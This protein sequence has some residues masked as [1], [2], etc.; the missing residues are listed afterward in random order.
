MKIAIVGY[1]IVGQATHCGLLNLVPVTIHDIG[2]EEFDSTVIENHDLIFMCLPTD[3]QEHIQ[4]LLDE[5]KKLSLKNPGAEFV[6]RSTIT[7]STANK[8]DAVCPIWTYCPEFLRERHWKLDCL[9]RPVLIGTDQKTSL[10]ENIIGPPDCSI[11]N[12]K[13]AIITKLS[14]NSFNSLRVVFANHIYNLCQ[15]TGADFELTIKQTKEHIESNPQ[16]YFDVNEQLRGFGGKCLPKDLKLLISD[17]TNHHLTQTLFTA[18]QQDNLLWPT[19][20]RQ[21]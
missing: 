14:V 9:Q 4:L 1:G 16:H 10:L 20:I 13:E 3:G 2:I 5:C 12:T 17:F 8:L 21:D 15:H 6:V 7:V 11:V 18:I 19:Y